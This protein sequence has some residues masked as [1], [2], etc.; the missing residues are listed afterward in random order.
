MCK[1]IFIAWER[2]RRS[3]N[4]IKYFGIKSFIFESKL[5]RIFKHP[6]FVFKTIYVVLRQ[7]PKVLIIQNPSIILTIL[8]IFIKWIKIGKYFLIVDA[9]NEGILP[10]EKRMLIPLGVYKW[11]QRKTNITIVTNKKLAELVKKNGGQPFVLPDKIPENFIIKDVRLEG[12]FNIVCICTFAKDEPIDEIITAANNLDPGDKIYLTGNYKKAEPSL[13]NDIPENLIF[14]GFLNENE[15][16]GYLKNSD[17]IVDLTLMDD[18]LVCGAYEALAVGKPILLS[19]TE[20]L[21]D[22]FQSAAIY[23]KNDS[24]SILNGLKKIK[25][26]KSYMTENVKKIMNEYKKEWIKKAEELKSIIEKA[27]L[28]KK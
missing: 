16:W 6:Y 3:E 23:T 1:V 12:K 9:H 25:E 24:Q 11:I 21:R 7:R 14:T 18:C 2:H 4:I 19:D 17:C 8:I 27:I 22:M 10:F 5:N 26:N 13:I 20:A 28:S 15:Y